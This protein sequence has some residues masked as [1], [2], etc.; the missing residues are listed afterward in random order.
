MMSCPLVNLFWR[1][2]VITSADQH[3]D[4][5]GYYKDVMNHAPGSRFCFKTFACSLRIVYFVLVLEIL[6]Y[7]SA[8]SF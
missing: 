7:F 5:T 6:E 3:D 1:V 4:V 2:G 8:F